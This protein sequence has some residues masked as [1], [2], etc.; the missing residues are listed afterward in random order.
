MTKRLLIVLLVPIILGALFSSDVLAGPP[1]PAEV[2]QIKEGEF[3]TFPWM[4]SSYEVIYL[5]G[6]PGI[7]VAQ[8][9]SGR[10]QWNCHPFI[11]FTDPNLL[12]LDEVCAVAPDY[13]N[14]NGSFMWADIPCYGDGD[15]LANNSLMIVTPNGNVNIGCRFDL[16]SP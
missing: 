15:I 7:W 1:W 6:S 14:G 11:D 13:C 10:L 4:N 8:Y 9:H 16:N 2:I 3:C 12:S 5:S